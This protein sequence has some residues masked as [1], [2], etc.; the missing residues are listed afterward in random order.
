MLLE[1][2]SKM[3][4]SSSRI[5]VWNSGLHQPTS[6]LNRPSPEGHCP[7]I[8]VSGPESRDRRAGL[9]A[10]TAEIRGEPI[11]VA[12]APPELT[13]SSTGLQLQPAESGR[14]LLDIR[15]SPLELRMRRA[16]IGIPIAGIGVP[17]GRL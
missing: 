5:H 10:P 3:N 17:C 8:S 14:T 6:R 7:G 4:L 11:H 15:V 2:N 9:R 16:S 13:I 1:P 12:H